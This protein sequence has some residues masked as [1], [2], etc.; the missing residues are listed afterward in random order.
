MLFWI[1]LAVYLHF[2]QGSGIS[3]TPL[4]ANA[5]IV[6]E[7]IGRANLYA[8]EWKLVIYY[9]LQNF[10]S[11]FSNIQY[12]TEK[13]T[14]ICQRLGNESLLAHTCNG[15]LLQINLITNNIENKNVLLFTQNRKQRA[16]FNAIGTFSKSLF[17]TLDEDDA[18]LYN[19]QIKNLTLNQNSLLSLMKSQ[20]LIVEATTNMFK[21][22]RDDIQKEFQ[23]MLHKLKSIEIKTKVLEY[24]MLSS[25]I[26]IELES[27]ISLVILMATRYQT[28]QTE[29][30]DLLINA[31][32][33]KVQPTLISPRKIENLLFK[34]KQELPN[35]V[36]L[37]ITNNGNGVTEIY[38]LSK[39]SANIINNKIIVELKFPLPSQ[40]SYQIFKPFPLPKIFNNSFV[41]IKST[42]N[43]I[44]IDNKRDHYL[45]FT[46]QELQD[47]ATTDNKHYYCKNSIPIFNINSEIRRCEIKLLKKET[48]TSECQIVYS[49]ETSYWKHLTQKNTWLFSLRIPTEVDVICDNTIT[50]IILQETGTACIDPGC[51]MR[52]KDFILYGQNEKTFSINSHFIPSINISDIMKNI[53]IPTINR[54]EEENLHQEPLPEEGLKNL[55]KSIQ[56][57]KSKTLI[58]LNPINNHHIHHYTVTYLTMS[59]LIIVICI[60]MYKNCKNRNTVPSKIVQQYELKNLESPT[61]KSINFNITPAAIRKL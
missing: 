49:S 42:N 4:N 37:P 16:L 61:T 24:R 38:R 27:L 32:H 13:I 11:E 7:E 31:H 51:Y 5:G 50:S 30:I 39:I 48:I 41:H 52:S 35:S 1:N 59:I 18:V 9:D 6:F 21:K 34:I 33:G 20:I 46:S 54:K 45:E 56:D 25:Q 47:C 57:Q 2:I 58:S 53:Q 28:T 8:N 36:M 43:F 22:T 44:L 15:T 29:I 14:G 3:I 17:G 10:K 23:I 19:E 60:Y 26:A 12:V 55:L 40:D